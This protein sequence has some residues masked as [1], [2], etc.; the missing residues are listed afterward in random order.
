[1]KPR[2]WVERQAAMPWQDSDSPLPSLLRDLYARRGVCHDRD[3]DPDLK[4]LPSPFEL[5]GM[6]QA[7]ECLADHLERG[8]RIL[9]IGDYDADG[10][11]STALCLRA[12]EALGLRAGFLLPD[13]LTDGY[14]LSPGL[15]SRAIEQAPELVITVDTGIASVEGVSRLREAGCAVIVTDHHLPGDELPPANALVDPALKPAGT[16]R[17]LAG[18]GVAFYLM[19]ALRAVLRERGYFKDREEPALDA[20][21]DLVAIGTVADLVPLDRINRILVAQ[22]LKRLRAGACSA[23]IR[24]LVEVSGRSL[25]HLVSDDIAFAIAPRINAAGRLDDMRLGVRCLLTTDARRAAELAR[26]LDDINQYRRERQQEMSEQALAQLPELDRPHQSRAVVQFRDD[27]HEGLVGIIASRIKDSCFRPVFCFAP[28]NDGLLKGSGRSIPGI[29]L[30]DLLDRVDKR[31]PGMI[32]R[33]GG[34][35]MAA[36]LTLH[37]AALEDFATA[38]EAALE[39]EDPACFEDRVEHDGA[40]DPPLLTLE[41]A[42]LIE[43]AGP[44]GQRFPKPVF[45]GRFRVIDTR[46]LRER[47]LKLVLQPEGGEVVDAILFQAPE[48]L[49]G[50]P[51]EWIETLYELSVNRFRG[52]QTLQLMLR[53]ARPCRGDDPSPTRD[54]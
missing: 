31:H 32:L 2:Q 48:S 17:C 51:P 23:G 8:S 40:L 13:R 47:H 18:V 6:R 20:L 41:Q 45:V 1:V 21:L 50:Q 24:A 30:R 54:L 27:W 36:G 34:H 15:V 35:A 11:T 16:G 43:T 4:R 38:L 9:V 53:E 42:Q 52:Q 5:D 25:E 28:G 44:W 22:G 39:D 29:H 12:L 37:P 14:G 19:L 7:A 26:A 33:F 46:V 10:A 3:A 49:L